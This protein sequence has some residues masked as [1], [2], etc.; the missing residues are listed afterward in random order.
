MPSP[1]G[2]PPVPVP[3]GME[4]SPGV[5]D[6][7][8]YAAAASGDELLVHGARNRGWHLSRSVVVAASIVGLGLVC[9]FG[10]GLLLDD[11]SAS[12]AGDNPQQLA[13][14]ERPLEAV[15]EPPNDIIKSPNDPRVYRHFKLANGLKALV[16]SDT[17]ADKAA[18]ALSVGS[19]S[20]SEGMKIAGLAH[21][22]EHMLFLGTKKY[23]GE[24]EYAAFI[25]AHGGYDNAYTSQ[26]ETN[27]FFEVQSPFLHDTLDRFAQFF[28]HPL[29]SASGASKEMHAVDSEFRK[30]ITQD[31]WRLQQLLKNSANPENTYSRFSVG[32]IETLNV[33]NIVDALREYYEARYSSDDM[34]LVVVGKESVDEQE[35]VVKNLFKDV[36]RRPDFKP[37]SQ[38]SAEPYPRDRLGRVFKVLAEKDENRLN[39][40]WPTSPRRHDPDGSLHR[41]RAQEF[42]CNLL[43]D[44]QAGGLL[45]TLKARGWA[46]GLNCGPFDSL[47]DVLMMNIEVVLTESG[48]EHTVEVMSAVY[49]MIAL[50]IAGGKEHTDLGRRLRGDPAVAAVENLHER[51]EEYVR[52]QA[53]EFRFQDKAEPAAMAHTLASRMHSVPAGPDILAPPERFEWRADLVAKLLQEMTPARSLTYISSHKFEK[54]TMDR[55]E[56]WFGTHYSEQPLAVYWPAALEVNLASAAGD[57]AASATLEKVTGAK[58]MLPSPNE[59][60]PTAD[61]LDMLVEQFPGATKEDA[62]PHRILPESVD[63][64]HPN[65]P[66]GLQPTEVWWRQ[67]VERLK[68]PVVESVCQLIL[69]EERMYNVKS[70]VLLGLWVSFVKQKLVSTAYAA[71]LAGYSYSLGVSSDDF[72]GL[73]FGVSGYMSKNEKQKLETFIDRVT[74]AMRESVIKSNG[75]EDERVFARVKE[76]RIQAYKNVAKKQPYQDGIYHLRLQLTSFGFDVESLLEAAQEVSFEDLRAF[77][78]GVLKQAGMRC[79]FNGNLETSDAKA[80]SQRIQN[81]LGFQGLQREHWRKQQVYKLAAKPALEALCAPAMNEADTN[82]AVVSYRQICRSDDIKSGA[83]LSLLVQLSKSPAFDTLRTK[84]QLGYI[85]FLVDF[86]VG[87]ARSL[88]VLVQGTSHDAAYLSDRVEAFL[89]AHLQTLTDITDSAFEDAKKVLKSDYQERDQKL[90]DSTARAWAE[91]SS[92]DYIF[93][94]RKREIEAVDSITKAELLDMYRQK[95]LGQG[96][97][98]SLR[99]LTV[100]VFGKDHKVPD[101]CGDVQWRTAEDRSKVTSGLK[102]W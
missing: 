38:Q 5:A 29:L 58:V 9:V 82:S 55:T 95:V 54:T 89:A 17:H 7:T 46:Q 68:R 33:S 62:I 27:F 1:G 41:A 24:G 101:Q 20:S 16:I 76:G 45:D 26:R 14:L 28:I 18:A 23:P 6:E 75:K 93:D 69:P 52:L 57:A 12:T 43:G 65:S 97:E 25:S 91:V 64:G 8:A 32:S 59:F 63:G 92:Q 56:K 30:D 34:T 96:D 73:R 50:L 37:F 77:A 51:W 99:A 2:G 79:V 81:G 83:I 44:E 66:G 61:K 84:E 67:G 13:D 71:E 90:G 86:D 102:T 87:A 21:F 72:L 88:T 42:V 35:K 36:P 85:V 15:Q 60:V 11:Q 80:L 98:A 100:E 47:D 78:D 49:Q 40:F 74:A 19:G 10:V 70:S 53:L 39:L 22:C 94:R 31:G 48:L 4:S 3:L